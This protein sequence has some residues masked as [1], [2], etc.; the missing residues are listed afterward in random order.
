MRDRGH[1]YLVI[2][3]IIP[4][5]LQ[6]PS[7]SHGIRRRNVSR[8]RGATVKNTPWLSILLLSLVL[9]ATPAAAD[10]PR[11]QGPAFLPGDGARDAASGNQEEVAIA[12]GGDGFLVA[13]TDM[14]TSK[15]IP[16]HRSRKARIL[17]D[18]GLD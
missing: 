12:A 7:L 15:G 5:P 18:S 16:L 10:P 17:R 4:V 9:V 14:R 8:S 3:Q 13:W 1:P 11:L 2:G 6:P